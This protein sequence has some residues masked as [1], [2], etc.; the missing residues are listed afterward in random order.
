MIRVADLVISYIYSIGTE[1]IF[2]VTGGSAM[3]LNDAIE[4]VKIIKSRKKIAGA[5]FHNQRELKFCKKIG[6]Q[7]LC[8]KVD[9]AIIFDEFKKMVNFASL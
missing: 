5:M 7:F 1:Y 4:L 9:S 3:F 6:I 8:Y 2:T